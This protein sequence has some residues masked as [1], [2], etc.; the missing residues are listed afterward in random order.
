ML[1][2]LALVSFSSF[3]GAEPSKVAVDKLWVEGKITP[4]QPFKAKIVAAGGLSPWS[5]ETIIYLREEG[6]EK[7][8]LEARVGFGTGKGIRYTIL[9]GEKKNFAEILAGKGYGAAVFIDPVDVSN[10]VWASPL[11]GVGSIFGEKDIVKVAYTI[12]KQQKQKA[13]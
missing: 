2:F 6:G 8:F 4:D 1:L 11:G 5:G 13:Q 3:A 7:R 12:H 9:K 10:F